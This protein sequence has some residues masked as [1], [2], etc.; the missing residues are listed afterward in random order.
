MTLDLRARY[1]RILAL[2]D[3]HGP[4][5]GPPHTDS[6]GDGLFE[7][8]LKGRETIG[9]I[10]FCYQKGQRL[11]LLHCFIKKTQRTPAREIAIARSRMEKV[12]EADA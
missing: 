2:I 12:R 11:V 6:F 10:F 5:L 7:I 4:D 9:R 8:R 1:L 3:A